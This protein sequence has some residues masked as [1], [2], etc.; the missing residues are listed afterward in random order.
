MHTYIIYFNGEIRKVPQY[1]PKYLFSWAMGRILLGL[2]NDFESTTINES[3]KFNC[4]KG[5]IVVRQGFYLIG[6]GV[7]DQI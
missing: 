1:I 6:S 2:Q 7:K 5:D 4:S 3:L